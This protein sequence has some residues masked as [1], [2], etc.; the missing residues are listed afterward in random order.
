[1]YRENKNR[2]VA[3]YARVSTDLTDQLHSLAAQIKY[4][5]EYISTHE[6]WELIEV[7]SDEGITGTSTKKRENFNRMIKDCENGKIDTILTKEVSRFARNTVDTLNYTRKLS[8]IGVNVIFMNDGIDTNDKDGELRLTIMASIAQEESRK[9]SERVKWGI[10][11]KMEDGWVYG[12]RGMLGFRIENGELHV[13]PEEAEVVKQI[14]HSYVYDGKGCHTIANEL[15]AAGHL[16][17]RGKM[18]REDG[19]NRILKNEKY[20]GDLTQWKHYSTDFISKKV[21]PNNGDNPDVPLISISEHHKGIISRE[22]WNLAQKQIYE[23]GKLA[24]EGKRHSRHYW[25]SNIVR[26]GCCGYPYN[27]GGKTTEKNRTLHCVNRA[28]YGT[29]HRIDKNGAEVGCDNKGVNERVLAACVKHILEYVQISKETIIEGLYN[30]IEL[31]QSVDKPIDIEPLKAEI[32]S[33]NRKKRKAIDLLLDE[34]ITKEDLK[35]QTEYYDG[36]IERLTEQIASGQDINSAHRKQ[37]DG[38]KSFITQIKKAV[39]TDTDSQEIYREMTSAI[40]IYKENEIHIYL[41]CVPFGFKIRYHVK[42]FNQ[43]HRFN[44]FID[45]CEVIE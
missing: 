18:W 28:K 21:L 34:L 29:T 11:R 39:D 7:Y 15:N 19:V 45:S 20:V 16:T 42:K 38:I 8:Q 40:K 36:E 44:V 27:I 13:V 10:R 31:I 6:G 37:I 12:A 41:N 14:F 22:V 25:F 5:T 4:F 3:A 35:K 2:K 33:Y 23:R 24:R 30:D 32:E 9:I 17:V 1:M 43:Q 26:C